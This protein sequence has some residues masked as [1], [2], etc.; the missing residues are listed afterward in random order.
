MRTQILPGDKVE[1][2]S[3]S[4]DSGLISKFEGTAYA[5]YLDKIDIAYQNTKDSEPIIVDCELKDCNRL[6]PIEEVS[7]EFQEEWL[8]AKNKLDQLEYRLEQIEFNSPNISDN[9]IEHGVRLV[10]SELIGL[11]PSMPN[12]LIP[13]I[14]DLVVRLVKLIE[15]Q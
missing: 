15:K 13:V 6:I 14:S 7:K 9:P 3:V 2:K 10:S 11:I 4:P 12:E 1:F 8:I 5:I